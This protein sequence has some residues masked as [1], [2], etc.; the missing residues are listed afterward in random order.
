[1]DVSSLRNNHVCLR[2]HP[3]PPW[4]FESE[5]LKVA[6]DVA[7]RPCAEWYAG[8]LDSLEEQGIA[9]SLTFGFWPAKLLQQCRSQGNRKVL[10]RSRVSPRCRRK[11]FS[12]SRIVIGIQVAAQEATARSRAIRISAFRPHALRLSWAC[13]RRVGLKQPSAI[14]EG[15]AKFML[16]LFWMFHAYVSEGAQGA[17]M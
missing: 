6:A 8:K 1:M 11:R 5:E 7:E 9:M 14:S 15:I 12:L 4:F 17:R 13:F 16:H 10:R 3:T 2:Q